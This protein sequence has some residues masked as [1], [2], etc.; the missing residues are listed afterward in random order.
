[1]LNK[2][3]KIAVTATLFVTTTIAMAVPFSSYDTRSLGMGG[4][5]VAVGNPGT[6]PLFNPALLSIA[7]P[8]DDFSL[9]LP[10]I[11]IR[12]ADPDKLAD[13]I[14]KFQAAM[15]VDNLT[16]S[17]NALNTA[18]TTATTTPN[19]A[20]IAAIAAPASSTST[21][22]QTLSTQ[23]ATLSNKPITID[24]GVSTVIA[25]PS[26][27][28]GVAFYASGSVATGGLFLYNDA[29]TLQ[30]LSTQ[31]ACL[32]S[33]AALPTGTQTEV[34]TA[35]AAINACGTNVN[36]NNATLQ[37]GINFR[38][39]ALVE[40]GL[41]VSTFNLGYVSLGITPKIVKAQ[42]FDVPI[43]VNNNNQSSL[44]GSDY[45]ANYSFVNF[46]LGVATYDKGAWR[47]GLVI[48]NIIPQTLEFK[49]AINPGTTPVATGQT[50]TLKP[51]VRAGV[52]HTTSWSTVA[53][54]L[55]ITRNNPAGF[56]NSTQYLALGGELNGWD[57]IQLRA[58]YRVDL[59]NSER[60]V[61]SLGL[62]IS[63]FGVPHIDIA[64]AGNATEI[65]TSVQLGI[66]F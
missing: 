7:G 26:E 46:D 51:L 18:I 58:G 49:R 8:N 40:A 59:V 12:V 28:L 41:A 4:V 37:S 14:D 34:N 57:W 52:S 16:A 20:N 15:S 32:A 43:N 19:S 3:I 9:L 48:K 6:A 27:K 31:T 33:A 1:M 2:T 54:D 38:G 50:L 60:N 62:G 10:A 23:L 53:L 65:G 25:I 61:A 35:V 29:P 30:T 36:F 22:L 24:G 17:A 13:S 64:V 42:L 47:T 5:G 11:G 55:D 45:Q 66:H 39:V 44:N 56:E 21:N 63:P